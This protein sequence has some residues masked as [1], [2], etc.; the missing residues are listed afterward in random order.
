MLLEF[1]ISLKEQP[2]SPVQE[3]LRGRLQVLGEMNLRELVEDVDFSDIPWNA[4]YNSDP[5]SEP[6][7]TDATIKSHEEEE[8]EEEEEEEEEAEKGYCEGAFGGFPAGRKCENPHIPTQSAVRANVTLSARR[9]VLGYSVYVNQPVQ[10]GM[11]VV[12]H[13]K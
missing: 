13:S 7:S 4:A 11:H 6:R 9:S 12:A 10:P 1:A 2:L 5:E 8:V 3:D